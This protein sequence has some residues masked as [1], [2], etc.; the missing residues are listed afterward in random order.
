MENHMATN[1]RP[2]RVAAG[3]REEIATFLQSEGLGDPR[4]TGLVTV[5][6]VESTRDLRSAKVF[7]S[8]LGAEEEREFV[9]DA[10]AARAPRLRGHVGRALRLQFAPELHFRLDDSVAR[11]N[12]IETLLRQIREAD[13]A[14]TPGDAPPSGEA[15]SGEAPPA[16]GSAGERDDDP[17]R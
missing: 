10:L 2:D 7:V 12:R 4:L 6:A 17:A 13:A 5:T 16:D 9:L 11:A 8:Y 1:R 14:G 3:L 15:P